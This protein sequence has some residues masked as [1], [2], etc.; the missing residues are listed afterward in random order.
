MKEVK[1]AEVSN[2]IFQATFEDDKLVSLHVINNEVSTNVTDISPED[3]PKLVNWLQTTVLQTAIPDK[4]LNKPI[5]SIPDAMSERRVINPALSGVQVF[6]NSAKLSNASS[7]KFTVP[8]KK[9]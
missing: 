4:G 7:I 5:S 3:I 6:D 2:L 1:I 9:T 8:G